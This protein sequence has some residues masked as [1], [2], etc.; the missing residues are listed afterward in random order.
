MTSYKAH[1]RRNF[2]IQSQK[3]KQKQKQKQRVEQ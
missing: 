2:R 3:Q 1:V